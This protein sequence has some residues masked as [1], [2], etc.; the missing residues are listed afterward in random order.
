MCNQS[1]HGVNP[2]VPTEEEQSLLVLFSEET[3][4]NSQDGMTNVATAW[5]NLLGVYID[6]LNKSELW[7]AL[8]TD[9]GSLELMMRRFHRDAYG[10]QKFYLYTE[11]LVTTG[12]LDKQRKNEIDQRIA[13][14]GLRVASD[15]PR[16]T[17]VVAA[18]SLWMS[19]FRPVY[20]AN[21]SSVK[22]PTDKLYKFCASFN[23]WLCTEYLQ[24]FGEIEIP[25]DAAVRIDR[26]KHDLT[27]RALNHS[28]LELLYASI[29]R[30]AA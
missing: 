4:V 11:E 6:S 9:W 3:D 7:E 22:M 14:L 29:F 10:V 24:R 30:V 1:T 27:Y 19:T 25:V 12:V 28:S 17:K 21:L 13:T 23:F 26:I 18:F 8:R 2:A 20:F 16:K 15:Q 5:V